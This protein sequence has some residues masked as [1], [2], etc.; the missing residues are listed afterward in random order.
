MRHSDVWIGRCDQVTDEL[1]EGLRS[2]SI[3][4]LAIDAA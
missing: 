4:R 2:T 1:R 3:E